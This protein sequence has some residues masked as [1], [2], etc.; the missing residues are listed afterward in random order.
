MREKKNQ[1]TGGD[2]C[3]SIEVDDPNIQHYLTECLSPSFI[4]HYASLEAEPLLVIITQPFT[5]R[6]EE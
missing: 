4:S 3:L 6:R 2:D 5:T 1:E